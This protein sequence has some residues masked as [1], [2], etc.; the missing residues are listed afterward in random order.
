MRKKP[1][2]KRMDPY[3][4][5]QSPPNVVC[6]QIKLRNLRLLAFVNRYQPEQPTETEKKGEGEDYDDQ[7]LQ[8]TMYPIISNSNANNIDTIL[9]FMQ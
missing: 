8:H 2:K 7:R 4:F 5:N 1:M 6:F 3:K 9:V